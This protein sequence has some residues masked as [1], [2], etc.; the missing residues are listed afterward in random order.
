MGQ[1]LP[2]T[3][4]LLCS[5][6][7]VREGVWCAEAVCHSQAAHGGNLVGVEQRV[8]AC[9]RRGPRERKAVDGRPGVMPLSPPGP[10]AQLQ[11]DPTPTNPTTFAFA[12]GPS[13]SHQATHLQTMCGAAPAAATPA[14]ATGNRGKG[15]GGRKACSAPLAMQVP[16]LDMHP[17]VQPAAPA[18]SRRLPPLATH[19]GHPCGKVAPGVCKLAGHAR[20]QH[21]GLVR[22]W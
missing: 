14:R 2:N 18:D 8:G 7:V 4:H 20:L 21:L 5:Q 15:E 11:A 17:R 22:G 16:V 19:K 1:P 13:D 6:L 10:G 9:K 3:P 12:P